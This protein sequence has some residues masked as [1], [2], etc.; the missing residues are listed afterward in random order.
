MKRS[1]SS[2]CLIGSIEVMPSTKQITE[3]AADAAPLAED[4]LAARELDDRI[5]REEIGRVAHLLDQP[6]LMVEQL[7][8]SACGG[9]AGESLR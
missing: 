9:V 1:N 4:L 7:A 2:S 6:E 8:D 3:L 5:D